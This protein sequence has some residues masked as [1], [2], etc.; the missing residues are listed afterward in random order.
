[1]NSKPFLS[2]NLQRLANF[3]SLKSSIAIGAAVISLALTTQVGFCVA[4]D[5]LT[6]GMQSYEKKDYKTAKDLLESAAKKY[7][8]S[9]QLQYVLGNTYFQLKDQSCAITAYQ[10]CLDLKPTPVVA[11]YCQKMLAHLKPAPRA[12]A[13]ATT[14]RPGS[15][16]SASIGENG[17]P[18]SDF[19]ED[20]VKAKIE[21]KKLAILTAARAEADRAR[22]DAQRQIA[23]AEANGNQWVRTEDSIKPTIS[24]EERQQINFEADQRVNRI[25]DDANRRA[26]GVVAP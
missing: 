11:G 6:A 14:P 13:S 17:L 21:A 12:I 8:T 16:S 1:M 2:A 4:T 10:S 3:V 22:K 24:R 23:E 9:A 15:S 26:N 18:K 19:S 5:D 25:M 20:P 7:P